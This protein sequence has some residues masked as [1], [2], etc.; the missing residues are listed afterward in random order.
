M[1]SGF[2]DSNLIRKAGTQEKPGTRISF[3]CGVRIPGLPDSKL[4]GKVGSG[5]P[6]SKKSGKRSR[7]DSIGRSASRSLEASQL[8]LKNGVWFL[9]L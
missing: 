2:P 1:G 5:F 7:I 4:S 6:D 3:Q 8:R 9:F